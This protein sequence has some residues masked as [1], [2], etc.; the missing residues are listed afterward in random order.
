M[1]PADATRLMSASWRLPASSLNLSTYVTLYNYG[2]R[3]VY[4]ERFGVLET[5]P[6]SFKDEAHLLHDDGSGSFDD[7]VAAARADMLGRFP[8]AIDVSEQAEDDH[9][10]RALHTG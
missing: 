10:G 8:G 1:I 5:V 3:N 6:M 7:A 9:R 4:V 2:Y